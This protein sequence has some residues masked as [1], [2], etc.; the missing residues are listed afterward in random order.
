[1]PTT[2][3]VCDQPAYT[4]IGGTPLCRIHQ[5]IVLGAIEE[6]RMQGKPVSATKIALDLRKEAQGLKK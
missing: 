3:L 2:C 1:M 4:W 6:L 5:V